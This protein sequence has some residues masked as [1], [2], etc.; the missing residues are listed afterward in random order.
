[1]IGLRTAQQPRSA[2]DDHRPRF[3]GR[4][5]PGKDL[6]GWDQSQRVSDRAIDADLRLLARFA[7]ILEARVFGVVRP[8][9]DRT[10]RYRRGLREV[11]VMLTEVRIRLVQVPV[12]V[13]H[14]GTV[15]TA[16]YPRLIQ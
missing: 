7:T 14:R 10:V 4:S 5:K 12:V 9:R 2:G 13:R 3:E 16:P 15:G 8:S 6:V 11:D 1:M